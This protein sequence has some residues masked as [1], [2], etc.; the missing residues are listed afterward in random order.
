MGGMPAVGG[1]GSPLVGRDSER[2]VLRAEIEQAWSGTTRCLVLGGE[3]G[4]GKTRLVGTL[5]E[6]ATCELVI[7]SRPHA[8]R[9]RVET[10]LAEAGLKPRIALE[11]ES[12][13]KGA[14]SL[15]RK[16]GFFEWDPRVFVPF[17]GSDDEGDWILMARDL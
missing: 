11:V 14:I 9:M 4:I 17:P 16:C 3:A 5:A 2:A 15:Y 6:L 7:P 13:N 1:V 10:A 12:P 8:L